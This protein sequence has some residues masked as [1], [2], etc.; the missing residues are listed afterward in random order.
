MSI[1]Y[2]NY[3]L[4]E[5]FD[6]NENIDRDK[7]P[8][9]YKQLCEE[10]QRRKESGEF[11]QKIKEAE[12][13][14]D[15]GAL[16]FLFYRHRRFKGETYFR[17]RFPSMLIISVIFAVFIADSYIECFLGVLIFMSIDMLLALGA[18][19]YYSTDL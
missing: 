4:D 12:K 6:V 1:N 18:W 17:G 2:S 15:R 13:P 3:T 14:D 9:R 5:F 10:I 19:L 11:K 8:E 16:D 7:Y